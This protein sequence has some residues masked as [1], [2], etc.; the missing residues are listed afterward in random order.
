[1]HEEDFCPSCLIDE[2]RAL[3]N[4]VI[5]LDKFVNVQSKI[6]LLLGFVVLYLLL[7]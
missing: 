2:V 5:E 1:M 6:L 3:D 4:E 7:K